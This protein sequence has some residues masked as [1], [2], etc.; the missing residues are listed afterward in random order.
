MIL[1]KDTGQ[2]KETRRRDQLRGRSC[3]AATG[4]ALDGVPIGVGSHD[5]L[6]PQN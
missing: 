5:C 1:K 6:P 3:L 4:A 2:I